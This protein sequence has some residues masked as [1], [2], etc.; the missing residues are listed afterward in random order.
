MA[1]RPRSQKPKTTASRSSSTPATESGD[2]AAPDYASLHIW[3]FQPVRD[4]LWVG[5]V[6]AFLWV[7][8]LL[9]AVTVPL[10]VALLLAY[11]VEPLVQRLSA[12]PRLSRPV[13][14]A[15]LLSTVGVAVLVAVLITTVLV[16]NQTNQLLTKLADGTYQAK[17]RQL[18]TTA[19]AWVD[20]LSAQASGLFGAGDAGSGAATG[21]EDAGATS[22][23]VPAPNAGDGEASSGASDEANAEAPTGAGADAGTRPDA[24][25]AHVRAIVREELA[26]LNGSDAGAARPAER[27]PMDWLAL[28][29]GAGGQVWGVFLRI[30][31]LGLLTFLIPFYFYFFSVSYPAVLNFGRKLLPQRNRKRTLDL[32]GKMDRVVAGFVR[33]RIIISLIMG[34]MLAIGWGF[35]GVPYVIP[36]GLAI[37]VFCAV[38]YLGGI[39]I[40]IAILLLAFDQLGLPVGERMSWLWIVLGPTVVFGVVQLFEGYV[41]T[42]LIAGKAT[43]LDPVAILVAVLAGGSILG[44][45]GMLISIPIAACLK[46]VWM[47]I[48]LPRIQRWTRGE[49]EDPLPIER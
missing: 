4:V 43:N 38:P 34:L 1:G 46:I 26:R 31:E 27:R 42:P 3:Q 21:P 47:E 6:L 32:F 39:G 14:V 15:A 25:D 45:F 12:H 33:G 36:L 20:D 9:S 13:V 8:Y 22:P 37:G 11:L 2:T 40:P 24:Q 7:G 29:R 49:V 16:V 23:P 35:C 17:A 10:L 19:S 44:V 41:L 5:A 48:L 30:L 28:V 18:A